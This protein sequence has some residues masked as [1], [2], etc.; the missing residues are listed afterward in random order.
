MPE[1]EIIDPL[2]QPI[3][4]PAEWRPYSQLMGDKDAKDVLPGEPVAIVRY[5]QIG[6]FKTR[7]SSQ[8]AIFLLDADQDFREKG[9][10]S[11]DGKG[12][13]FAIFY[14]ISR[15]FNKANRRKFF[16]Q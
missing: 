7:K 8:P 13:I 4:Y 2:Q 11:K 16:L 12:T 5:D 9:G 1:D 15:Y 14:A 3:D 10:Q 6:L